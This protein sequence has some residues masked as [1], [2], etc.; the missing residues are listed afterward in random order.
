MLP[1]VWLALAIAGNGAD[2]VKDLGV[3]EG[4]LLF[5]ACDL[6]TD[7]EVCVEQANGKL[8]CTSN[9]VFEEKTIAYRIEVPAGTYKVFARTE[10]MLPGVRAYYTEA[11]KCGLEAACSDHT[12]VAISVKAGSRISSVHPAD[13]EEP[14]PQPM[15]SY[16][17]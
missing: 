9:L 1:V 11:V 7:L 10:S 16:V 4:A 6:P 2:S 13:W 5:P 14:E 12:P 17:P 3:I 8:R 15:L